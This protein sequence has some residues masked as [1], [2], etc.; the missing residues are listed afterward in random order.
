MLRLVLVLGVGLWAQSGGLHVQPPQQDFGQVK[1]GTIVKARFTLVNQGPTPIQILEIKP[2]C[3]CSVVAWER[4]SLAPGDS[5]PVEVSFNTGGKVGRQRK[6]FTVFSTASNS[7]TPF[8]LV[9]LV[10]SELP[11]HN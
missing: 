3:G 5:L 9:G 6:T 1:Q 11:Q 7:P 8:Y 2:S 10:E 4:R